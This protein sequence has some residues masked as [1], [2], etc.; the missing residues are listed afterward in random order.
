MAVHATRTRHDTRRPGIVRTG[1][2]VE[3]V[4][5]HKQHGDALAVDGIDAHRGGRVLFAAGTV[6]LRKT[7]TLRLIGG[8]DEPT[9]GQVLLDGTDL[10]GMPAHRRPT[11]TVFQSYAARAT[12]AQAHSGANAQN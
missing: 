8:F 10:S 12:C 7:T 9:R 11:N 4:D 6:R 2:L 1:G 5:L 3:L